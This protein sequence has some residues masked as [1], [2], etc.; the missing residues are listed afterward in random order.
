MGIRHLA[1]IEALKLVR[2]PVFWV[3]PLVLFIYLFLMLVAYEVYA[4]KNGIDAKNTPSSPHMTGSVIVS[5]YTVIKRM[6]GRSVENSNSE[7]HM[8]IEE[9]RMEQPV[10]EQPFEYFKTLF[11]SLAHPPPLPSPNDGC[12]DKKSTGVDKGEASS[13]L[14]MFLPGIVFATEPGIIPPPSPFNP[15]DSFLERVKKRVYWL[16]TSVAL[17]ERLID[18]TRFNGMRFAYLSLYFAFSF[19]FPLIAIAVTAQMFASEFS[20]G[21]VRTCLLMPVR[22]VDLLSA[23]LFVAGGYLLALLFFFMATSLGI[24]CF[25]AG[26]GN[27]VI[28]SQ[29]LGV[30]NPNLIILGDGAVMLFAIAVVVAAIS[31]LPVVAF[32]AFLSFHKPEPA[33]VIGSTSIMY[34]I[35]YALGTLPLFEEIRVVF[36]TSYMDGWLILFENVHDYGT[37]VNKLAVSLVFSGVLIVL[38]N[39]QFEKKD[40]YE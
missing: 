18:R 11:R 39:R 28:D 5:S 29:M 21:T 35:F 7:D 23:K 2:A 32:A 37:L 31:L 6:A 24:G 30:S 12:P 16:T 38:M 20:H 34:F 22:R 36:F 25:F 8:L 17:D 13:W 14:S 33:Y 4:A 1:S 15:E 27:L 40:I 9:K 10:G 3:A 19:V 26:Y